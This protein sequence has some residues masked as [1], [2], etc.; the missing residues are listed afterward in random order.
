MLHVC[1]ARRLW[2]GGGK[3]FE[4]VSAVSEADMSDQTGAPWSGFSHSHE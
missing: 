4:K 2:A 3:V 1:F